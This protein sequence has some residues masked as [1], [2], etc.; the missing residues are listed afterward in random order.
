MKKVY[1]GVGV[2]IITL[3]GG[4]YFVVNNSQPKQGV[5]D[6]VVA[7][8]TNTEVTNST[9]TSIVSEEE[10]LKYAGVTITL[11][12]KATVQNQNF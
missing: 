7:T 12:K 5:S 8:R 3:V 6:H 2:V 10:R 9:S 1:V 4:L 11:Y